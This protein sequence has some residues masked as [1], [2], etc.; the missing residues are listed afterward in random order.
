MIAELVQTLERRGVTVLVKGV[1]PQHLNLVTRVGVL[2]S[3]RHRHHLFDDLD[4]AVAF[5]RDQV[6]LTPR[7]DRRTR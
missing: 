5:A 2:E 1:Q 7:P 6:P 4:A 3:L